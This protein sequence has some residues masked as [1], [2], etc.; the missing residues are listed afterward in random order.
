VD[1]IHA[2]LFRYLLGISDYADR[3][4][5][6]KDGRIIS[7]DE[8]VEDKPIHI[9]TVLKK[10]KANVL[11]QWLQNNYEKLHVASWTVKSPDQ[12]QKLVE[13]QNRESCL[14]LFQES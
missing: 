13:I 6:M 12:R 14:Q 8:D 4:F 2:V 3:N 9:Y 7:I 1:Y 10:N 5:V 11:Y